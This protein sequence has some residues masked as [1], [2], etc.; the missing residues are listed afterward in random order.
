M[1]GS[2]SLDGGEYKEVKVKDL[3][4][5]V[6][7][8]NDWISSYYDDHLVR[9]YRNLVVEEDLDLDRLDGG[10]AGIIVEGDLQVKG[11]IENLD[12]D[13]GISL[14]VTGE[15]SAN[16]LIAGGSNVILKAANIKHFTIGHYNGGTLCIENLKTK[17]TINFDH[18]TIVKNTGEIEISVGAEQMIVKADKMIYLSDLAEFWANKNILTDCV[19]FEE[20]DDEEDENNYYLDKM[21]IV[22]NIANGDEKLIIDSLKKY[23]SEGNMRKDDLEL[24]PF[25]SDSSI[26][27]YWKG[28]KADNI[29]I[30]DSE[31]LEALDKAIRPTSLKSLKSLEFRDFEFD[32]IPD[33]I[34]QLTNITKLN[35]ESCNLSKLP[36]W[37]RNFKALTSLVF[38]C[39]D[40]I[41]VPEWIGNL[42]QLTTLD[43]SHNEITQ[44]PDS[45]AQLTQL[46]TLSLN[47]N[48]FS[49]IP[50]QVL[51]LTHLKEFSIYGNNISDISN[52]EKNQ[53]Q[54]TMLDLQDNDITD[55]PDCISNMNKLK[56]LDLSENKI[57]KL[58]D[59]MGQL[60][61][62]EKL[63]LN[64]NKITELPE[65]IK[66]LD[67]LESLHFEFN[68]IV[69]IPVWIADLGK[70]EYLEVKG[71]DFKKLP[72]KLIEKF[73]LEDE[74]VLNRQQ[75]GSDDDVNEDEAAS[76]DDILN[77]SGMSEVQDFLDEKEKELDDFG[78]LLNPKRLKLL[79]ILGFVAA[80]VTIG[81]MIAAAYTSGPLR[82]SM[83]VS[84]YIIYSLATLNMIYIDLTFRKMLVKLRPKSKTSNSFLR[85]TSY[86][87]V[88]AIV[89]VLLHWVFFW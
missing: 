29:I 85:Y 5:S 71:N 60:V 37:I 9:I 87:L 72:K 24:P 62:L 58:P 8:S 1:T 16:N 25:I 10:Y 4:M 30:F 78:N 43:L 76:S 81:L 47:G 70:L 18:H 55:V 49:E 7:T 14:C 82:L 77:D 6:Y 79:A 52:L 12:G 23:L 48:E 39:N 59:S 15:T 80:I 54:L 65:W 2:N 83:I 66:K 44:I 40:E 67:E 42:K 19:E 84:Y 74:E 56:T 46:K 89:A 32:D 3:D 51:K 36:D 38:E 57:S 17:A 26:D 53:N 86:C 34:K 75:L 63:N 88:S 41:E 35:F 20:E 45:V 22:R 31:G 50:E 28:G 27:V 13:L 33:S 73:D 21:K 11:N 64:E 69:D 68:H 61:N